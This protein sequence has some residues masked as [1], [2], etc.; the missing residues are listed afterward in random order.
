MGT[1]FG[2]RTQL[3]IKPL[4]VSHLCKDKADTKKRELVIISRRW[5]YVIQDRQMPP[6][7]RI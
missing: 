5:L 1:F 4:G 6:L 3:T 7:P 2:K